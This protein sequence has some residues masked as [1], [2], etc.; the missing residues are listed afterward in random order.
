MIEARRDG[1]LVAYSCVAILGLTLGLAT[2]RLEIA[3][4]ATPFLLAGV[5][6][7]R[8]T[9][10]IALVATIDAPPTTLIEG[11]ELDLVVR[12]S[13]P[14]DT[15]ISA[16]LHIGNGFAFVDPVAGVSSAPAGDGDIALHFRVAAR[17]W[18]RNHVGSVTIRAERPLSLVHHEIEIV[19]PPIRVL[20][21]PL[22]LRALLDPR[23][24]HAAAGVHTHR[25]LVGPGS[26]FAEIR[27]WQIGDRWRDLNWRAT[28]A[29][30]APHV[31]QH[32]PERSSEVVVV[33]DT[34]NDQV[35]DLS[36][37]GRV[38]LEHCARA[39][40]GVATLHLAAQ[41]RVGFLA[42][43]RVGLW[44]SPTGG[45]RARYELLD[46]LLELGGAVNSGGFM[47][48]FAGIRAVPTNALVVAFTPLWDY[49]VIELLQQLRASGR[50]VVAVVID[51]SEL[52]PDPESDT[53]G[54]ARRLW[55]LLLEERRARLRVAGVPEVLWPASGDVSLA[56][57][58]L[59]ALQGS[60]AGR[61]S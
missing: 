21:R 47:R 48:T 43:G 14:I 9:E 6:G 59:R 56:I 35:G 8:D 15:R 42:H 22:R 54:S 45:D 52:L 1:R 34:F 26:D 17:S 30:G 57:S 55:R 13:R 32:H 51:T 37:V 27:A 10:S 31:N 46:T 28:A 2:G 12:I 50:N 60:R 41:D 16:R 25:R 19:G 20:P 18:G 61:A 38:A 3:A 29:R 7:L 4:L 49:R 23:A 11:D 44:L 33:V 5:L 58:R 53:D 36:P 24:A 39:A 40:W